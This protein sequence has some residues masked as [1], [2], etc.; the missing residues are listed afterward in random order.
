MRGHRVTP[1]YGR[2]LALWVAQLESL[3]FDVQSLPMSQGTPFA[4]VLLTAR[5]AREGSAA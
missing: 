4:N 1:V 3:G 5:V 2:T